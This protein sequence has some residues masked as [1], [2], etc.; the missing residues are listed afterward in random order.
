MAKKDDTKSTVITID[1]KEYKK[2]DLSTE[3]KYTID[4]IK[5]L[6]GKSAS[7][8]FDLDQIQRAQNSFT[9]ALI[10]SL[11]KTDDVKTEAS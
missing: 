8:K 9:N 2:E 5:N 6:Q 7:L 4:Q 1:G 11:Q 10:E 3:Q